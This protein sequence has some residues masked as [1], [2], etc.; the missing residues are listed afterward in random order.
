MTHSSE[1]QYDQIISHGLPDVTLNPAT[2]FRWDVILR[3]FRRNRT[4]APQAP[5]HEA[6]VTPQPA[7]PE[8]TPPLQRVRVPQAPAMTPE[9]RILAEAVAVIRACWHDDHTPHGGSEPTLLLCARGLPMPFSP[10][11]D[12]MRW[13]I[14][15]RMILRIEWAAREDALDDALIAAM[16]SEQIIHMRVVMTVP[17]MH[18]WQQMSAD[19]NAVLA[20]GT[21]LTKYV[22]QEMHLMQ[23]LCLCDA[24]MHMEDVQKATW[25]V[26]VWLDNQQ[27]KSEAA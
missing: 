25:D 27:Q 19:E 22:C 11:V 3:L 14:D 12:N 1:N 16:M 13:I 6:T 8:P 4:T 5:T 21:R 15:S 24:R 18:V 26:T 10:I 2:W 9:Q 7:L 20:M 17:R 23:R